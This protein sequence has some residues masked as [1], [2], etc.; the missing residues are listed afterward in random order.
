[1]G[2]VIVNKVILVEGLL[3]FLLIASTDSSAYVAGPLYFQGD[4]FN[5][6]DEKQ[7]NIFPVEQ[8]LMILDQL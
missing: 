7:I 6:G 1:M 5:P 8:S 4:T 3:A 2:G